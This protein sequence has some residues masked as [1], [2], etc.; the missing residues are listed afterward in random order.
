MGLSVITA[1]LPAP[2]GMRAPYADMS[3]VTIAKM[4]LP[5]SLHRG[6]ETP[7]SSASAAF[8]RSGTREPSLATR[9]KCSIPYAPHCFS[10]PSRNAIHRP[11][12]LHSALPRPPRLVIGESALSVDPGFASATNSWLDGSRSG[13]GLRLLMNAIRVPSADHD[14]DD[15]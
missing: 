14:G 2:I 12:W 8:T 7:R 10:S 4:L 15:S 13:S 6:C 9:V 3:S 11:S 5:S 1:A